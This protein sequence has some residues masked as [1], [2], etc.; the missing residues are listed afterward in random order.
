MW[1][2]PTQEARLDFADLQS[3]L[4]KLSPKLRDIILLV[5]AEG[6]SYEEV[7]SICGC[8]VGTV[9]SRANRARARLAHLL[10]VPDPK[11]IGPD[12][13]I[14]AALQLAA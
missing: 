3:A 11:E 1:A 9:K 5:G 14:M 4:A 13:V 12:Q 2:A 7:A 10:A 8:P 6:L